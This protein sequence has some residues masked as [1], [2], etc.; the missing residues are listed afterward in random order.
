V[1]ANL[2][3]IGPP[4][5]LLLLA[6]VGFVWL[7]VGERARRQRQEEVVDALRPR[8]EMGPSPHGPSARPRARS[9]RPLPT[10]PF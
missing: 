10:K 5:A 7:A 1:S 9:P 2:V 6:A 4:I 3:L 8:P